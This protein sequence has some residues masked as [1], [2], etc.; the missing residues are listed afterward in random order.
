MP[1]ILPSN[2]IKESASASLGLKEFVLAILQRR[3]LHFR[4][5]RSNLLGLNIHIL[6]EQAIEL[7][8]E[9]YQ[10]FLQG[11]ASILGFR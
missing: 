6:P 2:Y 1:Y 3:S 8:S 7:R 11:V 4:L 9:F 5:R 10:Y